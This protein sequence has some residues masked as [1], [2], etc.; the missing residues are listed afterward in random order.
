MLWQQ[1]AH[2]EN[3]QRAMAQAALHKF[4]VVTAKIMPPDFLM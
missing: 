4:D 1:N 2:T 3:T